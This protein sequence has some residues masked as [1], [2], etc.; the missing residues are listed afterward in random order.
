MQQIRGNLG[1]ALKMKGFY[2]CSVYNEPLK[3][4]SKD[5][6]AT[7]YVLDYNLKKDYFPG[8]P[9]TF[10]KTPYG[11]TRMFWKPEKCSDG[12]SRPLGLDRCTFI[13]NKDIEEYEGSCE[14]CGQCCVGCKY[15]IKQNSGEN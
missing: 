3:R 1:E 2:N 15:L 5:G 7:Q 14:Q 11:R 12:I 13:W 4:F 9:T 6:C 8:S 10:V